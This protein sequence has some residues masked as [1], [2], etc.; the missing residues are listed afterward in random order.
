MA[1]KMY[2]TSDINNVMNTRLSFP[3]ILIFEVILI[4]CNAEDKTALSATND[5]LHISGK[6]DTMSRAI[7]DNEHSTGKVAINEQKV[8]SGKEATAELVRHTLVND[9]FKKD[10]P[11][12]NKAERTFIFEEIDLNGDGKKEIFVGFR[13]SYYC[14]SGG[15]TAL[16]LSHKGKLITRFTV[17]EY[18]IVVRP[19][20][21]KGWR[22]LLIG[23]SGAKPAM[24]I[25]KWNGKIYPGNPSLQ[26]EFMTI[27]SERSVRV[28]NYRNHP[29]PWS[30]F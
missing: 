16:L 13:G 9:V 1:K 24:H 3:V 28:L 15:C 25:V 4:S 29:P 17:T 6:A 14:G 18:P 27:P 11:L 21:T 8:N 19:A 23:S 20:T 5:S 10:L 12:I 22:D 26:P 30:R 2:L 7:A